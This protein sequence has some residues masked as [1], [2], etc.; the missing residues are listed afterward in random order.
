[1]CTVI[2][3]DVSEQHTMTKSFAR[4]NL[5]KVPA[6]APFVD[7]SGT[8]QNTSKRSPSKLPLLVGRKWVSDLEASVINPVRA[9]PEKS[10][11]EQ[12]DT[13]NKY[14]LTNTL[15]PASLNVTRI[16]IAIHRQNSPISNCS[17]ILE[18]F[19]LK[20]NKSYLTWRCTPLQ[21]SVTK[22]ITVINSSEKMLRFRIDVIG[23]EFR[24][25]MKT[26]TLKAKESREID[27]TFCPHIIGEFVGLIIFKPYWP[28]DT[29]RRVYLSG[30][31][32]TAWMHLPGIQATAAY[33]TETKYSLLLKADDVRD[34]IDTVISFKGSFSIFNMDSVSGTAITFVKPESNTLKIQR[35]QIFIEPK[36]LVISHDETK[37]VSITCQLGH[38]ELQQ[39][40]NESSNMV[41]IAQMIMILG[42]DPDRQRI[43]L[44]LSRTEDTLRCKQYDYLI[45][46]FPATDRDQFDGFRDHEANIPYLYDGFKIIEIDLNINRANLNETPN[47]TAY[48][49]CLD[50]EAE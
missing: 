16:P 50:N 5:L 31:G 45:N 47:A 26:M 11:Q 35:S 34:Y 42:S 46:G 40:R 37:N 2:L 23:D 15:L 4:E 9:E 12:R 27:V 33:P 48:L 28:P 30:Y 21:E 17:V 6:R 44:I 39:F 38:H 41:T 18:E 8:V 49:T 25:P 43:T 14:E 32:G 19:S 36:K 3:A 1:M 24:V 29:E 20:S 22:T 13:T 7:I 10:S